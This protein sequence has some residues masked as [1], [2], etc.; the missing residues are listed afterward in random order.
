MYQDSP[1]ESEHS[2][3]HVWKDTSAEELYGSY[4]DNSVD[5][6]ARPTMGGRMTAGFGGA[7]GNSHPDITV[8]LLDENE[9]KKREYSGRKKVWPGALFLLVVTAGA[10]AAITYFAIDKYD[11]AQT[12]QELSEEINTPNI[13]KKSIPIK[14]K[15]SELALFVCCSGIDLI[16]FVRT[17]SY[18]SLRAPK[19][20]D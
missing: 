16:S 18:D 1:A 2:G 10:L 20:C 8:G 9:T 19:L 15:L 4:L 11:K 3:T 13:A 7:A 12:Q 17:I 14:S 5:M 6:H